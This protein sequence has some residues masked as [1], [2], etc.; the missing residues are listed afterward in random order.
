ML[1]RWLRSRRERRAQVER[2]AAALLNAMGDAAYVE[3]RDR[4]RLHRAMGDKGGDCHWGRVACEIADITGR[5]VGVTSA[6][7][8]LQDRPEPALPNR[9][10]IIDELVTISEAIRDLSHGKVGGTALHNAEAA[11]HRLVALAGPRAEAGGFQLRRA[12]SDLARHPE[13]S[14]AAIGAGI[15]PPLAESAGKALERLKGVVLRS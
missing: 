1:L 7:R 11:V 5:E 8:F 10:A 15:Y 14:A 3:A 12:L 2:D 13:S 9:K 4:A 6:D